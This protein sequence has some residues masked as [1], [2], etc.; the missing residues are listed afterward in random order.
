LP[1]LTDKYRI[2]LFMNEIKCPNCNTMFTLDEAGFENILKQ[3]KNS[4][5]ENELKEKLD[6]QKRISEYELKNR[7]QSEK[8]QLNQEIAKL[9]ST[10]EKSD[11][12]NKLNISESTKKLD[13][14]IGDLKNQL[15]NKEIEFLNSKESIT[16]NLNKDLVHKDDTIKR[17]E[18]E[19]ENVK[20]MKLKLSTKA[21]GESL[22]LHCDSEFN[23]LR[24][25]AFPNAYFEKDNDSSSGSKGDYIFREYDEDNN[26]IVSIMF[27]M[28][29]ESAETSAKKRNE[30][31]FKELD[32]DRTEKK[33]EYAVLVTLL[34]AESEVYNAG[35]F[36]VSHK[37]PK[38]Y[39]VRPQFFIPIITLLRNAALQSLKFK[40]ELSLIKNQ[41]I[42]INNFEDNLNV[43]REGFAKNYDLSNR[44][45]NEA[46]AHIDKSI[47]ELESTK[48]KLLASDNNLRLANNKVQDLS[49]KKLTKGNPTMAAKFEE[50]DS[51][52]SSNDIEA[53]L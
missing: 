13:S 18:Q 40:K 44:Q 52:I 39:V 33:C 27:E 19:I 3:V 42:D 26:E 45:F 7:I 35:I 20:N 4:E 8:E 37:Y 12:E 28:K 17:L 15:K 16:N 49:I 25:A 48:S 22:E 43:F 24:S 21:I 23:K 38:M 14:E 50:L 11:I 5:F 53:L 1:N 51:N 32:K 41:N 29:N 2:E 9:R 30:D 31:F 34:E 36:D 46:I 47:K 10:I 6:N